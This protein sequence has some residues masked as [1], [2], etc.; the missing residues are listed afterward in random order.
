MSNLFGP[1][2]D[3]EYG[4][5]YSNENMALGHHKESVS[6]QFFQL[7]KCICVLEKI[8]YSKILILHRFRFFT[9]YNSMRQ[10]LTK[11]SS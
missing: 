7:P 5:R 10:H 2:Q 9:N 11:S 1:S 6:S 4:N 8:M 3:Y